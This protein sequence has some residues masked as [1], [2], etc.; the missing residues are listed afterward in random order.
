MGDLRRRGIIDEQSLYKR[1]LHAWALRMAELLKS[2]DADGLDWDNL[3]EELRGLAARDRR[4][5]YRRILV[6]MVQLLKWKWQPEHRSKSWSNSIRNQRDV[7]QSLLEQ[8]PSL[9]RFV[10]DAVDRGYPRAAEIAIEEMGLLSSPM[11]ATPPFSPE[12]ALDLAYLPD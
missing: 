4:E 11:P 9:R 1:D 6:L 3:A 7:L 10:A 5:L 12:Q 8:S 2:R